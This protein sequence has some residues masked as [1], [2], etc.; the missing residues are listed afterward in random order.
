MAKEQ[1]LA[2]NPN[3]I[4]GQCGRLLCCLD[5]EYETYCSLRKT[6]PKCGKR[7]RTAS[8]NGVI[9]KLNILTG[10]ITLRL[11]DGK[12]LV[13][14][15]DEVLGETSGEETSPVIVQKSPGGRQDQRERPRQQRQT[16][17]TQSSAEKK[18]EI[19]EA[20]AP[21]QAETHKENKPQTDGGQPRSGKRKSRNRKHSHRKSGE[22]GVPVGG[23]ASGDP[24]RSEP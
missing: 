12:L 2:L 5:Y 9:D 1:N 7:V 22:A 14:K 16:N 19:V 17:S 18:I 4:S 23:G 13:V 20:A 8:T 15:R 6:F 3:K 10:T 21:Q 11:D 24:N